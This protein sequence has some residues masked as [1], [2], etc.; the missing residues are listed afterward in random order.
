MG[1][2][3]PA[4]ALL[5]RVPAIAWV[6][7]AVVA[8][9]GWQRWRAIDA[10][11]DFDRA[12]QAAAAEQAASAAAAAAESSRRLKAVQESADAAHIQAQVDR[13]AADRARRAGDELRQRLAAV[14]ASGRPGD[15]SAAG[16]CSAAWQ[17]VDLLAD[18]LRRADTRAGDLA[19]Y[20]D[21]ARTAGE[22][23]E[24]AYIGLDRSR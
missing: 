11:E 21:S 7:I 22:A 20:A 23:C 5:G 3:S 13:A 19:A 16:E 2:I 9:G 1:L 18:V 6:L 24:R 10:R 17:A 8:W 14:Q 4:L 15:P 12:K